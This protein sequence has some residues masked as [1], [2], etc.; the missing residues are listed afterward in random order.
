[1]AIFS[2]KVIITPPAF[3]NTEDKSIQYKTIIRTDVPTLY[4]R[5]VILLLCQNHKCLK[6]K[7]P[8]NTQT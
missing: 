5:N 4:V 3:Q 2:S 1:M 6:I 8:E 7:C